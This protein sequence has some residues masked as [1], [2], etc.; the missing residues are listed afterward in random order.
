[1]ENV[2]D[3]FLAR[4][5]LQQLFDALLARDYDV[6][7]PVARDGSIVFESV[8][9]VD[10][11]PVGLIDQ[12][13]PGAY[14]LQETGN[15][16]VFDWTNGPQALKPMVF[17]PEVTLWE[18][19]RDAA[20]G[21]RFREPARPAQKR[22]V[23]G[24]RACDLAALY[25][26]DRHFLQ[27]ESPEPDYRAQRQRLFL[28]AV[29]CTRAGNQCFCASTGDGPQARYGYDLALTEL[30]QG[31]LVHAHS[32]AGRELLSALPTRAATAAEVSD[33]EKSV[34]VAAEQQRALPS[35]DLRDALLERLDHP[36]W[37]ET[38]ERCL[39]CGNCTAVCPTC[40]CN[41]EMDQPSLDGGHSEHVR[42]WD[43]CFSPDHGYIHGLRLREDTAGQYRQ[44]LTHKLATWHDQ[45]GRSG[46]VGCGRCITWCPVGIDLVEEV[47][48]LLREDAHG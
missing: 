4:P 8:E 7:G 18:V 31:F 26:H 15:E 43:S 13:D 32:D 11:L 9:S 19:A 37:K 47:Q 45:Y 17:R 23:V 35:R 48:A 22:A 39:G 10:M 28:V 42:Q 44:W 40:F 2:A 41:Q 30:E 12:Q 46:C 33:A 21:L 29:N 1:M 5:D 36:R 38:A 3:C 14:R 24:V 6:W 27:G 25:I 16:R 20:G 34:R